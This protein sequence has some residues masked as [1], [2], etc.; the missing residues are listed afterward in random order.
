MCLKYLIRCYLEDDLAV[1]DDALP[2]VDTIIPDLGIVGPYSGLCERIEK[3]FLVV[4]QVPTPTI[5][6][7]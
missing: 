7:P 1:L 3:T 5:R 6:R 2:P 4:V